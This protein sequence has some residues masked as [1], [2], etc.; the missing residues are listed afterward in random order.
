MRNDILV[1]I[2][3]MGAATYL[4]RAP[5]FLIFSEREMPPRFERL[6]RHVP[7]AL[8]SALIAP[9]V[10]LPDAGVS[11]ATTTA[12]L[13]AT[14]VTLVTL[15]FTRNILLVVASGVLT[16]DADRRCMALMPPRQARLANAA[17][18]SR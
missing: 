2:F 3:G 7:V 1:L 6:L 18:A 10:L 17:C 5:F 12:Y 4:T 14:V 8:L 15:R 11:A 13:A 9:A 16:V